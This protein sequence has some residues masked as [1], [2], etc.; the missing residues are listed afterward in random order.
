MLD[1][2]V[3]NEDGT[4]PHTAEELSRILSLS[5]GRNAAR[6]D[7]PLSPDELRLAELIA[8]PDEFSLETLEPEVLAGGLYYSRFDRLFNTG[9]S[10]ARIMMYHAFRD[11]VKSYQIENNISGLCK[12]KVKVGN[13][14]IEYL[15]EEYQLTLLDSDCIKLTKEVA[16]LWEFFVNVA[17]TDLYEL[18]EELEDE[19]RVNSTLSIIEDYLPLVKSAGICVESKSWALR[20]Q[21]T[22]IATTVEKEYPDLIKICLNEDFPSDDCKCRY[23]ILENRDDTRFPWL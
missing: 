23:F 7:L 2:E 4:L 15:E 19:T 13:L 9:G 22:W 17:A 3:L 11:R 8:R 1:F 14:S 6:M 12:S 5:A 21:D 10:G 18:F 16:K 20:S